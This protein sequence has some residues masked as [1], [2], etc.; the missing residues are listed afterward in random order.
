MKVREVEIMVSSLEEAGNRFVEAYEKAR[1]GEK[2]KPREILSFISLDLMRQMLTNERIRLLKLIR[3]KNPKTIYALAKVAKRP[4]ANVFRD[5]K[6][7]E[8]LELID[9]KEKGNS[10]TPKAKY[11]K[12]RITVPV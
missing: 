7:L 8:E 6:K 10:T 11:D 4:Y 12:L 9:L 5:V 3:E 2:V 1:K